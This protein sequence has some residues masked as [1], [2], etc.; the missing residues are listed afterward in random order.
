[1][2]MIYECTGQIPARTTGVIAPEITPEINV[3]NTIEMP[4][5]LPAPGANGG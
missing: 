1:L 2:Q 4:L 3:S 5:G